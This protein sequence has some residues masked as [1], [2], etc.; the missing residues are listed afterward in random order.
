[1]TTSKPARRR[2]TAPW[3]RRALPW[4]LGWL[5]VQAVMALAGQV[6]AAR[7]DEGGEGS[8]VIRRVRTMGGLQLRPTNPQLSRVQL[9]LG[10]G[11][12]ELDLTGLERP[13]GGVDVAVHVV[14]G[15][16][17][18][19]VPA[20]WRVWWSFAGVGGI[21]SDGGVARTSDEHEADLRIRAR[22]LFGGVGVQGVG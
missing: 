14:M 16:V 1:M 10:M 20:D 2:A 7:F 11:G 15:G 22:V 4:V 8:T 9:D 18:I 3:W 12:V 19:E 13:A 17:G 6:A 21:G 5:G